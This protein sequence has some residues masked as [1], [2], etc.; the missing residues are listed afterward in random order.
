M[1]ARMLTKPGLMP[2]LAIVSAAAHAAGGRIPIYG[3]TVI[4]QP[5]SYYVT[6]N[7]S[8]P[9]GP[10]ITIETSGVT[11]DLD[12]HSISQADPNSSVIELNPHPLPPSLPAIT[13]ANGQLTGGR[14]GVSLLSPGVC[15]NGLT[16]ELQ[17]LSI[18][19][20]GQFGINVQNGCETPPQSF[21]LSVKRMDPYAVNISGAGEIRLQETNITGTNGPAVVV[22]NSGALLAEHVII[23][24]PSSDGMRIMN[25]Q[26][27]RLE[28]VV[29]AGPTLTGIVVQGS[30]NVT[31]SDI[32]VYEPGQAGTHIEN[33]AVVNVYGVWIS[34]PGTSGI[35]AV[36]SHNVVLKD[37]EIT[38]AVADGVHFD[39]VQ[40]GHLMY[41]SSQQNGGAGI[42]LMGTFDVTVCNSNSSRNQ[43]GIEV[44]GL[45]EAVAL[46]DNNIS[47]NTADGIHVFDGRTGSLDGNLASRNGGFGISFGP[48][49][50]DYVYAGNRTRGN[51]LGGISSNPANINGG[52]NF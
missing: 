18:L 17:G 23:G 46:N 35:E 21:V 11:I 47:S 15:I 50:I 24:Y 22:Q 13:I 34:D 25:V 16:L 31:L 9:T 4:T 42:R 30:D 44:A 19:N 12:G 5:G 6:R 8:S 41:V 3:P 43:V 49:A 40:T 29:V 48:N 51:T 28:H 45:S 26:S 38:G 39:Q 2:A 14:D 7:F 20:A 10:A 1:H 33:S 37:A 27:S 32:S 36:N 52:G